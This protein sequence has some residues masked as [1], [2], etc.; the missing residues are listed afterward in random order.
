M[1]PFLVNEIRL[2]TK[3]N[4]ET[5]HIKQKSGDALVEGSLGRASALLKFGW[6]PGALLQALRFC[7]WFQTSDQRSLS[8]SGH[9]AFGEAKKNETKLDLV[10]LES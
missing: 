4:A 1:K 9:D 5:L 3:S 2:Q 8:H 7:E 6:F 10:L